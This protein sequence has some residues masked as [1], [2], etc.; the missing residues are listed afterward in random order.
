M[1]VSLLWAWPMAAPAGYAAAMFYAISYALMAA[2][3]FGSIDPARRGAASK[4]MISMTS[5]A[6]GDQSPGYALLILFVMA[7]LAGMPPFLGFFAKLVVIQAALVAGMSWLAIVAGGLRRDRR[8]LLPAPDPGD[9][10]RGSRRR[11]AAQIHPD[12]HLRAAFVL[13][14]SA[15]LVL[16]IFAEPLLHWCSAGIS[17]PDS[18]AALGE[19]SGGRRYNVRSL[20]RGGAVW[21]LVG[22]IT[23]RSQVQILPPLPVFIATGSWPCCAV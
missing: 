12:S 6:C 13:N 9:V 1:S 8:V 17:R 16:G 7:S 21:Q 20:M 5:A 10:L 3:A 18:V 14:A 15:L 2:A 19:A 11:T 4:P 22:L 23:R